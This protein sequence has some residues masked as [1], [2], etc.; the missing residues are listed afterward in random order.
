MLNVG[1]NDI[2]DEGVSLI[3]KTLRCNNVLTRLEVGKLG[4]TFT[5][6]GMYCTIQNFGRRKFGELNL[7]KSLEDNI[8]VNAFV[9]HHSLY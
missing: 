9:M 6:Q 5:T 1:S 8:L 4:E 3:A 2:G 7:A